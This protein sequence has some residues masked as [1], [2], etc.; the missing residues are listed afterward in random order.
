MRDLLVRLGDQAAEANLERQAATAAAAAREAA[1]RQEEEV[2]GTVRTVTICDGM[3][4]A[5]VREWIRAVEVIHA[6]DHA[7]IMPVVTRTS[8][9]RLLETI[10]RHVAEQAALAVP[11][12]REA[13]PWA[14]LRD[15]V[16]LALLGPGDADAV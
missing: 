10:E 14:G 16:R 2:R 11:V 9:G 6:R 4:P 8:K 13:V 5:E 3:L 12:A 7:I 15:A 1:R